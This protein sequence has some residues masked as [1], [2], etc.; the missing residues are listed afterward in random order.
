MLIAYENSYAMQCYIGNLECLKHCL[1]SCGYGIVR[2]RWNEVE[3]IVE[4]IDFDIEKAFD[5]LDQAVLVRKLTALSILF[6]VIQLI[7]SFVSSRTYF[8]SIN[9]FDQTRNLLR[10]YR[11]RETS[12]NNKIKQTAD[13]IVNVGNRYQRSAYLFAL[14]KNDRLILD[15]KL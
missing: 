6:N 4:A 9:G 2:H 5:K 12:S 3:A 13:A 1:Q 15:G 14:S 10:H 7:Y 8:L 11:R